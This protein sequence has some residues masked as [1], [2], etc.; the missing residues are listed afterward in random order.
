MSTT[1]SVRET[2][3]EHGG[4]IFIGPANDDIVKTGQQPSGFRMKRVVYHSFPPYIADVVA[5]KFTSSSYSKTN[6]SGGSSFDVTGLD[7]TNAPQDKVN[8]VISFW[9]QRDGQGPSPHYANT[10]YTANT[11]HLPP[12]APT[13]RLVTLFQ[14]NVRNSNV[15]PTPFHCSVDVVKS[16]NFDFLNGTVI[17]SFNTEDTPFQF[18]EAT[19]WNQVAGPFVLQNYNPSYP[20]NSELFGV[21]YMDYGFTME[22]KDQFNGT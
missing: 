6:V 9:P 17:S 7:F 14:A 5:N 8:W 19:V 12:N 18:F 16:W 1:V 10:L 20:N 13:Y 21:R 2:M 22:L 11:E 15:V 3:F 4:F